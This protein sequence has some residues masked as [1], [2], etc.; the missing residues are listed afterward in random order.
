MLG[1]GSAVMRTTMNMDTVLTQWMGGAQPV[2]GIIMGVIGIAVIVVVVMVKKRESV[3]A[4]P[5][6]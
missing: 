5:G 2:S 6:A 4:S 3:D 1:F